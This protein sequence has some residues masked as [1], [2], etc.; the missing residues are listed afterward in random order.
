MGEKPPLWAQEPVRRLL[1]LPDVL[2][3][4]ETVGR[5]V[6]SLRGLQEERDG[7][8]QALAVSRAEVHQL[9]AENAELQQIIIS[10]LKT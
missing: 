2:R 6:A 10:R 8:N 9:R 5:L 7:L 4:Q 1:E 3:M